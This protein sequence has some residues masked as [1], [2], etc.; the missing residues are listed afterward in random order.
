M[1]KGNHRWEIPGKLG[2]WEGKV[3]ASGSPELHEFPVAWEIPMPWEIPVFL[4]PQLPHPL[5]K[6]QFKK[7]IKNS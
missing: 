6:L 7:P 2:K 4:R 3:S 5:C 1:F